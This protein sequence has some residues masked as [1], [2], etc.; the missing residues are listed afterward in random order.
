MNYYELLRIK[1]DRH[2]NKDFLI[3]DGE[4]HTYE[5]ILNDSEEL[6]KQI[7]TGENIP[8]LICSKNIMFQLVSFFAINYSKNVPIICHY[9]LS[10]KVLNDILLKNNISIIISDEYMDIVDLYDNNDNEGVKEVNFS[11]FNPK[12]NVYIYQYK[13]PTNYLDKSIC[14]GVLSSGSTGVPKALYRTYESWAGFFP[15]QNGVFNISEESILFINGTLSFTGNLNSIISVLY[16]GASVV[17]SSGLNCKLWI[18]TITQYNI[19][20]IYL[21]PT[22]LQLLV[23]HLKEPILKVVSIF[24]GSQLLFE[25]TAKNLKKYMPKSEVVLYYGASELNYITYLCYDELIEK[26]LSVGRPFPEIDVYIREGKIFVNTEYAVYNATKPYSVNDIGYFDDDGY[27]IFEGRNDD[28][29]NIGGFKVSYTKVEN[30]VKKIPQIENAVVLPYS[31]SIRGSQ[32]ALFV[33]I[34]DKI[35]KK[36][37]LT[38]MREN[39][40]KNEIPRK[41]IFLSSFPYTS[42]EKID[43]LALLKML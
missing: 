11:I 22:K 43:R 19:T 23:K 5:N 39:L 2:K 14:M 21:I 41:V 18:K 29:V 32:I 31:D 20:N 8:I 9:N 12:F 42:S 17:I 15:V 13:N 24:T 16:E 35:T 34:I 6:G 7:L 38:K 36:D 40:I 3:V 26:P 28:I 37:L 1:R 27:L 25:D 4:K 30:E 10:K 33:T